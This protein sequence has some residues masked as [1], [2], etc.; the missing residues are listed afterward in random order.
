MENEIICDI[1]E[2]V[3]KCEHPITKELYFGNWKNFNLYTI[4]GV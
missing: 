1:I 3:V 4:I 2:C